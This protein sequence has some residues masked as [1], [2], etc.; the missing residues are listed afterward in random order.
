M[1]QG[2]GFWVSPYGKIIRTDNIHIRQVIDNPEAF[3]MTRE[4]VEGY[5]A[6]Y[7]EKLGQE[8]KARVEIIFKL[9]A[10]GWVQIRDWGSDR[11]GGWKFNYW[12]PLVSRS[13]IRTVVQKLVDGGY[14]DINDSVT[15]IGYAG[16]AFNPVQVKVDQYLFADGGAGAFIESSKVRDRTDKIRARFSI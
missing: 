13:T 7:N 3:D 10:E 14:M 4:E 12:A 1:P 15:C 2:K 8:G 16:D 6:K 5:Y 11:Y 9:L